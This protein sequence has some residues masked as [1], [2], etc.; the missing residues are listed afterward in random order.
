MLI[1]GTTVSCGCF[2]AQAT[3]ERS[4]KLGTGTRVHFTWMSMISRTTN[5][6]NHAYHRYGGRGI[7]VCDRWLAFPNFYA[8]MS[9]TYQEDLSIDRIDNNGDYEPS[10]C[11]WATPKEQQRNKSSNRFIEWRG[12]SR[13]LADWV[14]RTGISE[15]T[16]RRRL[17]RGWSVERA[18]TATPRYGRDQRVQNR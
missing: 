12:E 17:E 11:R 15:S 8:D 18:L 3:S 14:D 9:P 6:N 10:N 5:P 4:K 1:T 13:V 2:S 7:R 16:I